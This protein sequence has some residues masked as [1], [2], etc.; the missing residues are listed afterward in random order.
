MRVCKVGEVFAFQVP[1]RYSQAVHSFRPV[2]VPADVLFPE[3]NDLDIPVSLFAWNT[4]V[5]V[6]TDIVS[7]PVIFQHGYILSRHCLGFS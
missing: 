5:F 7:Q 1:I 3:R 2:D 6:Q 4:V